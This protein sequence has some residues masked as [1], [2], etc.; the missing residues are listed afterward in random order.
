MV[1]NKCKALLSFVRYGDA[2]LLQFV[3]A[4][5]TAISASGAYSSI[6]AIVAACQRVLDNY[7]KALE[8][9]EKGSN[10]QVIKKNAYKK[11]LIGSMKEVV[12][13]V[14]N[15]AGNNRTLLGETKL[16]L[17]K[18]HSTPVELEPVKKFSIT[19]LNQG[20]PMLAKIQKGRGTKCALFQYTSDEQVTAE[21]VWVSAGMTTESSF[22]FT[23]LPVGKFANFRVGVAGTR[24]Q[25]LF[26]E[27]VKK[28]VA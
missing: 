17:S 10:A 19:S 23:G 24:K 21:T 20:G 27:P 26:T 14:N 22:T 8:E 5:L 18:E 11:E 13:A 1:I 4:V 28:M 25:I 6:S 2:K 12:E 16:E 9:A 3:T 7:S 15:V